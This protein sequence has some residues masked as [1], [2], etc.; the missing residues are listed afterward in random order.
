[1]KKKFY[2]LSVLS[3]V[4]TVLLMQCICKEKKQ[5]QLLFSILN[6]YSIY[7]LFR[8]TNTQTHTLT[9]TLKYRYPYLWFIPNAG[10]GNE[11]S[12]SRDQER[13]THFP[14]SHLPSQN[15]YQ[16]CSISSR[17]AHCQTCTGQW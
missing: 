2:F 14:S 10:R 12:Q 6:N 4:N 16:Y 8:I 5:S 11:S 15:Q 7:K 13:E 3:T 1:M 9:D 17:R